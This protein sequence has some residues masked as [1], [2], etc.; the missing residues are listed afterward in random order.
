MQAIRDVLGFLA[1]SRRYWMAPFVL[2]LLLFAALV[3]LTSGTAVAPF[4]YAIF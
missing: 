2:A 4:I 1:T 3:G